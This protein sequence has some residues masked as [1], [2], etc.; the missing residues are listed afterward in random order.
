MASALIVQPDEG[1]SNTTYQQEFVSV[2]S[3]ENWIQTNP[4]LIPNI[5]KYDNA[6]KLDHRMSILKS[7]LKSTPLPPFGKSKKKSPVRDLNI[8]LVKTNSI[9]LRHKKRHNEYQLLSLYKKYTKMAN[10]PE[11]GLLLYQGI[12]M[13]ATS[14]STSYNSWT[15]QE[16]QAQNN[17]LVYSL[18]SIEA[19]ANTSHEEK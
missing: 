12:F 1:E 8:K 16:R 13:I 15:E 9:S 3:L 10:I 14:S 7:K 18:L 17:H 5:V 6:K 4:K 11:S 19:L 2:T